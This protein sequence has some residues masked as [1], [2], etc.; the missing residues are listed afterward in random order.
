MANITANQKIRYQVK[1]PILPANSRCF[2]Y[3]LAAVVALLLLALTPIRQSSAFVIDAVLSTKQAKVSHRNRHH[4]RLKVL[5]YLH[6]ENGPF[7]QSQ[8]A[9]FWGR[10]P[11]LIRNAFDAE[12]LRESG[13]WPNWEQIINWATDDE[14]E[15]FD[16]DDDEEWSEDIPVMSRLVRKETEEL[17]SF[18]LELGPFPES[19]LQQLTSSDNKST[20]NWT[21]L[22][23][24]VDRIHQPL[25]TWIDKVFGGDFLPRWR[26]DD[27]QISIAK[28]GGGIGPHVDNYDVFLIQTSGRRQWQIGDYITTEEEMNSLIDG[29]EVRILDITEEHEQQPF[30]VIEMNPGDMLYLPPRLVH[31]GT[32]L[33]DDCM[34]LSVGCRAPSASEMVSKLAEYISYSITPTAVRRYTDPDLLSAP[35]DVSN[36]NK[37]G[38]SITDDTKQRLKIMVADA[39]SEVLEDPILWDEMVGSI[40]TEPK[41]PAEVYSY[42]DRDDLDE[43]DTPVS[44]V[45]LVVNKDGKGALYQKEGV[46]FATSH[47]FDAWN[48]YYRIFADGEKFEMKIWNRIHASEELLLTTIERGMPLTKSLLQKIGLSPEVMTILS[49]LLERG[50][51][52]YSEKV[53]TEPKVLAAAG[54]DSNL[55]IIDN[56]EVQET[57][58]SQV[59]SVLS[60]DGRGA[61][62]PLE[63]VN[64]ATFRFEDEFNQYFRVLADGQTFEMKITN[65][66]RATEEILLEAIDAGV[67][68]T[69]KML[70]RIGMSPQ[71]IGILAALVERGLYYFAEEK[72]EWSRP[73]TTGKSTE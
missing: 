67:P 15:D 72:K 58:V 55:A 27:G 7:R 14:I 30:G 37:R 22:V 40:L 65:R 71:V 63:G 69:R 13:V 29:L 4:T 64:F 36:N 44:K 31:W 20:G 42:F 57:P 32:A 1:R 33:S 6:A 66:K 17:I 54:T 61:L 10:Q 41:R 12:A 60:R 11:I 19:D 56:A 53:P 46:S 18:T 39:I 43:E 21:L 52:Y 49:S 26:R 28:T 45:L 35:R 23:N 34:T 3:L 5:D 16:Y 8:I 25:S 73:V 38:C 70:Q 9:S 51:L 47:C 68:I 59:L 50:Y 24:D 48:H 2:Q 62:Y